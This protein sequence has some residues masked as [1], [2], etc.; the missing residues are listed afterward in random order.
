MAAIPLMRLVAVSFLSIPLVRMTCDPQ[1][2]VLGEDV[3][4][5]ALVRL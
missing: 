3:L 2:A 5:A 1:S 4:D